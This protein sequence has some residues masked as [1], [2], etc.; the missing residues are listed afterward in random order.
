MPTQVKR[1]FILFGLAV[2][3][4]IITRHFL[5]P[6]SFGRYGHY[7]ANAVDEIARLEPHYAGHVAC[8]E[9]HEDIVATRS[10]SK[11][12]VVA[13]EACH[14][15]GL[16]HTQNPTEQK[17]SLPSGRERCGYCHNYDASRPTG[18]PQI[19]PARHGKNEPCMTCHNPHHPEPT[20]KVEACEACHAEIVRTLSMGRHKTLDC[21]TC[22]G[23]GTTH[24]SDPGRMRPDV[25][26]TRNFCGGCHSDSASSPESVPRIDLSAHGEDYLCWQCHFPHLPEARR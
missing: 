14:G 13:C 20:G 5:V 7:R 10:T 8:A 23:S 26:R 21:T 11:H 22:H 19:D 9:C 15:P 3:I 17:M 12:A 16:A 18:F 6:V 24:I 1:L 2:A 4:L 25:P